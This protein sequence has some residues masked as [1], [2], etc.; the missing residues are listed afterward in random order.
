MNTVFQ[1]YSHYY[2]LLNT[3]KEYDRES[4]YVLALAK[5]EAPTLPLRQILNLG[6][7]TGCHDIY[8]ARHGYHVTG[9]DRSETMLAIANRTVANSAVQP[10]PVFIQGDITTLRLGQQFDLVLSLFHVMSYQTTAEDLLKAMET[11]AAHL[12]PGGLFIFDFW[13]GPA[14]LHQKPSVRVK[15]IKNETLTLRRITEPILHDTANTVEVN[16]EIDITNKACGSRQ[17][18]RETHMMRYL[19]LPEITDL[20]T[21]TGFTFVKTEEWLT[22][23]SP[24]LTTWNVCCVAKKNTCSS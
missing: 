18:L 22:G 1:E 13:Y 10:L 11:A 2:D 20:L 15:R 14:V 21:R 19:F 9:V 5:R 3:G 12:T 23:K 7:G 6:C 8:L 17:T 4:N 24:S 16:F